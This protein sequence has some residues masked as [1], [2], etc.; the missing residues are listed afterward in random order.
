MSCHCLSNFAH[1][2]N[3]GFEGYREKKQLAHPLF[4][5]PR[6]RPCDCSSYKENVSKDGRFQWQ[7]RVQVRMNYTPGKLESSKTHL[8]AKLISRPEPGVKAVL[9]VY[10]FDPDE[11][12]VCDLIYAEYT[13]HAVLPALKCNFSH[14]AFIVLRGGARSRSLSHLACPVT[15]PETG[16][17]PH[18]TRPEPCPAGAGV[19]GPLSNHTHPSPNV[20]CGL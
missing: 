4:G 13:L 3:R 7:N 5:D 15:P 6:S 12:K 19:T 17:M 2:K 8:S 14:L 1:Y 20:I 18:Y 11:D 10:Y 16:T 9:K